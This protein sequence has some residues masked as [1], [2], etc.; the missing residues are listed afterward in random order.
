MLIESTKLKNNRPI[1]LD[2]HT[3]PGLV[4]ALDGTRFWVVNQLAGSIAIQLDPAPGRPAFSYIELDVEPQLA[5][6]WVGE[7]DLVEHVS[8]RHKSMPRKV[9]VLVR[10]NN[11][12][13]IKC[14]SPMGIPETRY[15]ADYEGHDQ[16]FMEYGPEFITKWDLTLTSGYAKGLVMFEL[17]CP[18]LAD[19]WRTVPLTSTEDTLVIAAD[20]LGS[21]PGGHADH[22]RNL[23]DNDGSDSSY[24]PYDQDGNL[25]PE[26]E[27]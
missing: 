4:W 24:Y 14:S 5:G 22:C 21:D 17:K 15:L 9:G 2:C 3:R 16:D 20:D 11:G 19:Y 26:D 1:A 27:L 6:L 23:V 18:I 10:T 7:V 13:A 12:L 8:E 25:L